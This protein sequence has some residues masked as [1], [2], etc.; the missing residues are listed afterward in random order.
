MAVSL[1][2][3][4][5]IAT[6]GFA[7]GVGHSVY[8][9]H[10]Q[11]EHEEDVGELNEAVSENRQQL[12]DQAI[13]T[14][15]KW[16]DAKDDI[17][18]QKADV[19][20]AKGE[21]T[22]A[23]T[24]LAEDVSEARKNITTQRGE[25]REATSMA[26]AA[27]GVVAT[28]GGS[29]SS[30]RGLHREK[31]QEEQDKISTQENRYQNYLDKQ[32]ASLTRSDAT[33]ASNL[34]RLNRA[35]YD[36]VG[37]GFDFSQARTD[38]ELEYKEAVAEGAIDQDEMSL[39][40]YYEF[41]GI[42]KDFTTDLTEEDIAAFG[43][44][45]DVTGSLVHDWSRQDWKDYDFDFGDKAA[46]AA[47]FS[48]AGST[49]SSFLSNITFDSIGS[50]NINPTTGITNPN[51]SSWN[52]PQYSGSSGFDPMASRGTPGSLLYQRR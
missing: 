38:A 22:E 9:G 46:T 14:K 42:D 31:T 20:R 29:V 50:T 5:W 2:T 41:R 12:I 10:V 24:E 18:T 25:I 30:I 52:R 51:F 16:E 47:I 34:T 8:S 1:A 36:E 19:T 37:G 7:A 43:P 48:F 4:G 21:V 32:S 26:L 15:A 23:E 39:D 40:Q 44:D 28:A 3:W 6:G 45:Y 35:Y 27:R 13:K 49:A 11:R 17:S 33:L